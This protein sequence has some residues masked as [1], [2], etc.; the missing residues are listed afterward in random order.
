MGADALFRKSG[1][2]ATTGQ[3]QVS[4]IIILGMSSQVDLGCAPESGAERNLFMNFPKQAEIVADVP[5]FASELESIVILIWPKQALAQS[6]IGI[7]YRQSASEGDVGQQL[8]R[9]HGIQ[10]N[11]REGGFSGDRAKTG[12]LWPAQAQAEGGVQ[13]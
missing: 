3:R 11:V 12:V 5:A 2:D 7:V 4:L 13:S 10:R 9:Y 8:D 1:D 6:Y